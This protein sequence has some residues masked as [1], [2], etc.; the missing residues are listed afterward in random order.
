MDTNHPSDATVRL[1]LA[2]TRPSERE[3]PRKVFARL[4]VSSFHRFATTRV[5][6]GR[7]STSK[8]GREAMRQ[9]LAKA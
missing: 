1:D 8:G 7:G 6:H 9:L 2:A 3:P 4:A 5:L